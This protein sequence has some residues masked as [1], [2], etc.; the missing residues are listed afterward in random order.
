[1]RKDGPE[2]TVTTTAA[3]PRNTLLKVNANGTYSAAGATP[4]ELKLVAGIQLATTF[5]AGPT[6]MRLLGAGMTHEFLTSGAITDMAVPLTVAADGK[7]VAGGAGPRIAM[8]L[9]A[10]ASGEYVEGRLLV[11]Q[12]DPS[13]S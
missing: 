6:T 8:P 9:H 11:H 7:V 4:S 12:T 5:A 10:A 3:Y 13:D 1:M 2:I